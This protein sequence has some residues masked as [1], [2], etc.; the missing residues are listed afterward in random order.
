MASPS[1]FYKLIQA[2]RANKDTLSSEERKEIIQ[3]SIVQLDRLRR[4]VISLLEDNDFR[5][6]ERKTPKS[7][8]AYKLLELLHIGIA[9]FTD[10]RDYPSTEDF[11]STK[12]I[13]VS[14]NDAELRY[15]SVCFA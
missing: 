2:E 3:I 13:L 1:D 4:S 7:K 10:L 11:I 5:V 6:F 12:G 14:I 8:A 9:K 15:A